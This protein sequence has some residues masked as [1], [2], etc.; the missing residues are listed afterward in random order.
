MFVGV[1]AAL[2]AGLMWGLIFLVPLLLPDYPG[3]VL[4]FGRYTAFGV[5][6]IGLAWMDRQA[7]AQL[8]WAD[9][10]EAVKL[11]LVGNIL[12]YA[13][14]ATAIQLS[15]APM[16]TLIIGTLPVVIAVTANLLGEGGGRI[17][18]GRLV[19]PLA[20]IFGGLL[21]VQA[22]PVHESERGAASGLGH[23]AGLALA[24]AA[25]AC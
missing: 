23:A 11:S 1:L 15:G 4:A 16:P 19:W 7:L 14:L 5:L 12:Y 13:T 20:I 2:G 22:G 8:K 6:A 17:A 18:W 9:W 3:V 24:I 25:V 10:L 21:V